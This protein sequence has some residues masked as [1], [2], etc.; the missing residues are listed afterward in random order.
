MN[1]NF[2]GFQLTGFQRPIKRVRYNIDCDI[3]F[4]A[5]VDKNILNWRGDTYDPLTSYNGH[6]G[7]VNDISIRHDTL[8]FVS[9]SADGLV[10]IWDSET[11]KDLVT[12]SCET[13]VILSQISFSQDMIFVVR[14]VGNNKFKLFIYSY[15]EPNELL[16]EYQSE[17]YPLCGIWGLMDESVLIGL[18][19]GELFIYH[20]SKRS[21][22][23]IV[24]HT[25]KLNDIEMSKDFLQFITCSD[26]FSVIVNIVLIKIWDSKTLTP[27]VSFAIGF[28]LKAVALSPSKHYFVCS[29]GVESREVTTTKS[30]IMDIL[31]YDIKAQSLLALLEKPHSGCVNSL[32]VRPDGKG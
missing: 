14:P 26:D 17:G 13:N 19:S 25:Q 2:K 8:Q 28:S 30:N 20:L 5:S 11:A 15:K 12:I 1:S 27:I 24:K 18:A 22:D 3:L 4:G 6:T 31:F 9:G 29:G 16:H 32:Q 10:K 7:A 23:R 21:E